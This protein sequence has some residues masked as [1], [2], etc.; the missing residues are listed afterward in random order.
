VK[1]GPN[2]KGE[3][4]QQ[5]TAPDPDDGTFSLSDEDDSREREAALS[6]PIKGKTSRELN[7]VI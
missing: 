2:L 7:K 6:S 4:K 1:K 5:E 3:R